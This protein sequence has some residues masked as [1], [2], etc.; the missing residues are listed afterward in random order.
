MNVCL[1]IVAGNCDIR[2][3]LIV[4]DIVLDFVNTK[5]LQLNSLKDE[6]GKCEG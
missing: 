5:L 3:G 4:V 1:Y 6:F 2:E